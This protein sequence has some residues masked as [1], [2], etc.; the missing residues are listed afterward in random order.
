MGIKE[1]FIWIM[2][3]EYIVDDRYYYEENLD[4]SVIEPESESG[5]LAPFFCLWGDITGTSSPY[6]ELF[7]EEEDVSEDESE[8]DPED[9][10]PEDDELLE[11]DCEEELL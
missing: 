10:L 1:S 7:G 4:S 5:Y 2:E 9:E 11:D 6:S 8:S 3:F